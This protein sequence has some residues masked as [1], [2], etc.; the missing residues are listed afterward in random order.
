M[1]YSVWRDG[2]DV[3][4]LLRN[5]THTLWVASTHSVGANT[6]TVRSYTLHLSTTTPADRMDAVPLRLL[7]GVH[8][9]SVMS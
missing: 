2:R 4:S 8:V 3:V 1:S 9:T 7:L 5:R 6:K